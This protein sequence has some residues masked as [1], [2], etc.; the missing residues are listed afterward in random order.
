MILDR[1]VIKR[2]SSWKRRRV[3]FRQSPLCHWCGELTHKGGNIDDTRA[4]LDH[5]LSRPE[6]QSVEQYRAVSNMVLA[7]H[8]CNQDRAKAFSKSLP[9]R[10]RYIKLPRRVKASML[11]GFDRP[12]LSWRY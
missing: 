11:S 8:R 9:H 2:H 10:N 1:L 12:V 3:L 7:C 6:C 5:V 4:T